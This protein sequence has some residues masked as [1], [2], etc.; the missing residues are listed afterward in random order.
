M[1]D[2]SGKLM[3]ARA[4]T[5]RAAFF[6]DAAPQR[7]GVGTYY[8]DLS[9][10]LGD[11]TERVE[12]ICPGQSDSR[13]D[14]PI[15]LPLPGDATQSISVPNPRGLSRRFE[16]L[17]PH[18]VVLAT[19][20]PYGL[21]GLRLAR[22]HGARIVVGFHTHFEK[23]TD[24]YWK[25][26]R[27]LGR[28]FRFYLESCNR[29]MFRYAD[30]V[31]ANSDEM[32]DI[33]RELGA[34]DTELMGTTIPRPFI[35]TPVTALAETLGTVTF[36]GRLAAEK[37]LASIVAA[38]EALPHIAFRVAGDGPERELVSS[39]AARL[40]NFEYIGWQP[41][42]RMLDVIDATDLLVLPSHVESFGTI[43][44]EAMTRNRSV[45]V[46]PAC[47]ITQW[48]ALSPGL[49]RI[50][51]HETLADAIARVASLDPAVRRQKAQMGRE[52]ACE[53]NE[54]TLRHWLDVLG[55]TEGTRAAHG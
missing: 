7:N 23:L 49:F 31:L 24:L 45:L 6:S 44:L 13:W 16:D 19:P 12:M 22:K 8:G 38:A 11:R 40:D 18:A 5:L 50:A 4:P 17:V 51:S 47:G 41:R 20:G 2:G 55:R 34:R 32:Q 46:S 48:P 36:A 53:L 52:A 28:V 1:S 39:A 29:L 35:D 10:H 37:N 25:N 42:Q 14:E 21:L 33:A 3:R 27:P 54:W 15:R 9:E 30:T 43:A 26:R